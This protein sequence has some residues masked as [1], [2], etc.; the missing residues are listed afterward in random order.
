VAIRLS[1][2]AVA[3]LRQRGIPEAWVAETIAMPDRTAPDP[4]DPALTRSFRAMPDAGGRVL[5][6]VHR[7]LGSDTLVITAFLDR[8][9]SA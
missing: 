6:V 2:H 8:D 4:T 9:V 5:R 1:A 7:P 3:R